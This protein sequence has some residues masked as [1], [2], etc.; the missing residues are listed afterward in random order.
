MVWGNRHREVKITFQ[1]YIVH[2][3]GNAFAALKRKKKKAFKFHGEKFLH[4][5]GELRY[6]DTQWFPVWYRLASSRARNEKQNYHIQ[7]PWINQTLILIKQ[8]I[9][10]GRSVVCNCKGSAC[11]RKQRTRENK[12]NSIKMFP[13]HRRESRPLSYQSSALKTGRPH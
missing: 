1:G 3:W 11:P 5:S 8:A 12:L 10:F 13:Q 4:T 9:L 2:Q 6:K 7:A